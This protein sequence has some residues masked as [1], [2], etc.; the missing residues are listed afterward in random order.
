MTEGAAK[1]PWQ[2]VLRERGQRLTPQRELVLAAVETL[3]HG[4]PEEI[5]AEVSRHA[6][7]VNISTVYRNLGLLEEL[8]A[9][10]VVHL[11]DRIPTY[12]SMALPA[13]VHLTC[14]SCGRVI[15]ADPDEFA[16][17]AAELLRSHGFDVDLDR[18]VLTG[19]CAACPRSDPD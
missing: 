5:H 13:H 11:M 7:A 18:L 17:L 15:D 1:A 4:T 8:G 3:G 14:S 9:V 16:T 6:P 19:R 10:R 12:H 2:A